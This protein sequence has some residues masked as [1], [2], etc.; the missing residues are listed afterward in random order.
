M[1]TPDMPNASDQPIGASHHLDDE[2]VALFALG[3]VPDPFESAHLSSCPPCQTEV[4][5]LR[6][7][8][9]T[10]KTVTVDDLGVD[11]PE[12]VWDAIAAEVGLRE[13]TRPYLRPED[14]QQQIDAAVSP[15]TAQIVDIRTKSR[16]RSLILAVAAG[17]VGLLGGL[18]VN[19]SSNSPTPAVPIA[20]PVVAKAQLASLPGRTGTGVAEVRETTA[21]E[22]VHV[23]ASGL[24][25][26]D[27]FYQV[28]LLDA[29]AKRMYSLGVL[30]GGEVGDFVIP[31][32]VKISEYPIVDV[33]LQLPNGN[34]AHSKDSWV[35]GKLAG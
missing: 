17:F 25:N 33:S 14:V 10:A 32:G 31:Q 34:P 15:L 3:E 16:R 2:S 6:V 13:S 12:S 35:R 8:V 11:A 29:T 23:D 26:K 20:A 9:R 19:N 18:V 22:I 5:Q 7:M 30:G 24:P 21:G 4:D 27:G 1:S 28:W